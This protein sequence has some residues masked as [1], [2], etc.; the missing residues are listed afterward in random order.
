[1]NLK[2][3]PDCLACG[4][5]DFAFLKK[6]KVSWTSSL[7]GRNAVQIYPPEEKEISLEQLKQKLEPLGEVFYNGFLLNFKIGEHELIIF[8][9]GRVMVKGT[10]DESIARSLYAKYVG[11]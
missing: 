9:T 6:E 3:R 1:M 10:T 2:P 7:C 4:R 11:T 5:R 8:P